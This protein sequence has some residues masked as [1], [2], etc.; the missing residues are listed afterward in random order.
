MSHQTLL[1]V[2][3][4]PASKRSEIFEQMHESQ[5][6]L[7]IEHDG[8][9]LPAIEEPKEDCGKWL[10]KGCLNHENHHGEFKG[11]I[12]V[13]TFQKSC[14]RASCMTCYKKWMGRESNK[15]TR[16]NSRINN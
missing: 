13:K 8:W 5:N 14:Y 4:Y 10:T 2:E 15:A 16:S 9:H 12:F 7:K 11:K 6:W 1:N 3:T